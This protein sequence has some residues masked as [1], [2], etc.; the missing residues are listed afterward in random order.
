VREA[1]RLIVEADGFWHTDAATWWEDM[2][3]DNEFT[4]SGDRVLRFP[5]FAVRTDPDR[6]ARQI[7]RTLSPRWPPYA[8]CGASRAV[9]RP[10]EVRR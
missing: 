5:A 4:V 10:D 6:V 7:S 3:R 9:V 8:G 2:W 1:A